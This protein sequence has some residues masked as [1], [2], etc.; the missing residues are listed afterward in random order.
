MATGDE[1]GEGAGVFATDRDLVSM[2]PDLF[3]QVA[4]VGQ[5]LVTSGSAV[6]SSI[7]TQTTPAV[8]FADAGV[9][10]GHVLLLD[11]V[12]VE[13]MERTGATTVRV[14]RMRADSTAPEIPVA[15][16]ASAKA[17]V[18][19]FG[20]QLGM[21]HR[22]VL[23]MLGIEPDGAGITGELTESQITNGSALG[24]LEA[25]GALHQV[26]AA[27]SV[28]GGPSS[29]LAERAAAYRGAFEIERGRAVARID[30][31][32]DGKA[33]ATRRPNVVQFVRG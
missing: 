32:G 31:D 25:L 33:D 4:W 7:V 29:G 27:A 23:R 12:P 30:L 13:V 14:S 24:R 16:D 8:S 28:A 11:G 22:Q 26:Y 6:A 15:D 17:E 2:E 20:P 10:A 9:T 3:G 1:P 21:V 18:F 19:T 5:R